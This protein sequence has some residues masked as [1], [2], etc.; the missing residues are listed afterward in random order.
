MILIIKE[1]KAIGVPTGINRPNKKDPWRINP[2]INIENYKLIPITKII[3][4][5]TVEV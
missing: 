4:T 2:N 5:C 1:T 3:T